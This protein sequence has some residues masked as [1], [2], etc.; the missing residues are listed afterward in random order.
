M[1]FILELFI[2]IEIFEFLTSRFLTFVHA[3]AER[4]SMAGLMVPISKLGSWTPKSQ[5][6]FSDSKPF[7]QNFSS[8]SCHFQRDTLLI[9]SSLQQI[10][11]T[12]LRLV[13][14]ILMMSCSAQYSGVLWHGAVDL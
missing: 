13:E 1:G 8:K 6:P 4:R 12:G 7:L 5:A 2:F 3:S 9:H 14:E 11:T 10:Q